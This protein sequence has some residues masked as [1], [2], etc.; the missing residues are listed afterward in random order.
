MLTSDAKSAAPFGFHCHQE[1]SIHRSTYEQSYYND[2]HQDPLVVAERGVYITEMDEHMLRQPLWLQLTSA[3]FEPLQ[4]RM[5]PPGLLVHRYVVHEWSKGYPFAHEMVEVHVDL[6]DSFDARRAALPLGGNFSV[7]WPFGL[8]PSPSALRP[9]P[10]DLPHPG[11]DLSPPPPP[12]AAS[13][14]PAATATTDPAAGAAV[15]TE[16]AHLKGLKVPQLKELLR[17]RNLPL[18]GKKDELIERLLVA[19]ATSETSERPGDA[20]SES[21]SD[22]GEQYKVTKILDRRVVEKLVGLPSTSSDSVRP[23]SH[24]LSGSKAAGGAPILASAAS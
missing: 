23:A 3:E 10:A 14:E 21:G 7:R 13:N 20:E 4:A 11:A 22:D 16:R 2:K 24:G 18:G 19:T 8:R 15:A 17:A 9:P 6:D 1:C 12:P 5:P